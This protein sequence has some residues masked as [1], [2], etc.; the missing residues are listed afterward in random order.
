[1]RG[2]ST[3]STEPRLEIW[4]SRSAARFITT[5]TSEP[6]TSGC[7]KAVTSETAPGV[8][9]AMRTAASGAMRVPPRLRITVSASG[10]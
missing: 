6:S 1:M 10:S 8:S 9:G 7:S 3:I 2:K 5:R 4:G